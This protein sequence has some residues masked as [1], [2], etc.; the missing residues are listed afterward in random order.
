MALLQR[1]HLISTEEREK[2]NKKN[3]RGFTPRRLSR[4]ILFSLLAYMLFSFSS[5]FY[6]GYQLKGEIKGL[7]AQLAKIQQ[8]NIELQEELEYN[9]TPE[10]IEKIAREKLGL[11]KPGEIV[12]MRANEAQQ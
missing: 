3:K 1:R 6:Q 2:R 9:Y 4:L 7:E 12:I 8:E 10:A 11:I 5:S